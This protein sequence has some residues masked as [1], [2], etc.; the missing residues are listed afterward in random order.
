RSRTRTSARTCGG[1][2]SSGTC[3]SARRAPSAIWVT[4]PRWSPSSR[5]A[6]ASRRDRVGGPVAAQDRVADGVVDAV[7]RRPG[8]AVVGFLEVAGLVEDAAHRVVVL[9]GGG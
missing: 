2:G 6:A 5:P 8:L 1:A 7:G 3:R 9:A 4:R